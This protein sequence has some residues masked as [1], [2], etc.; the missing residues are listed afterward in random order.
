MVDT[1]K[2]VAFKAE[3]AGLGT[4]TPAA[5]TG[6]AAAAGSAAAAS[7]EDHVH[8]LGPLAAALDCNQQQ[9]T[10]MVLHQSSSAPSPAAKGQIYMDSDDGKVYI[11]TAV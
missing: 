1:W 10:D 11:C 9:M 5:V 2:E 4:A 7:K 6:A 8:A 3:V